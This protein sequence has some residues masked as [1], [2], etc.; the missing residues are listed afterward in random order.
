MLQLKPATRHTL[1]CGK[2][3]RTLPRRLRIARAMQIITQ[4]IVRREVMS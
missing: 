4:R 2:A 1:A 3:E